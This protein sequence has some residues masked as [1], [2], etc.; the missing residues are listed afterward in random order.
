MKISRS[1]S[2]RA[3]GAAGAAIRRGPKEGG[4]GMSLYHELPIGFTHDDD[5]DEEE[6]VYGAR[7]VV[8]VKSSDEDDVDEVHDDVVSVTAAAEVEMPEEEETVGTT[9]VE[10]Q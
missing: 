1:E 3:A 2:E 6:D 10:V 9:E 8:G 4:I 7:V 5:D